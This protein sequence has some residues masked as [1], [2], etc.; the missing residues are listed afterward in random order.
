MQKTPVLS[1][2]LAEYLKNAEARHVWVIGDLLLDQYIE[3]GIERISPEAPV[4]VVNVSREFSRL[5]GAANVANGLA[6]LGINVTLAGVIGKDDAGEIFRDLCKS[7]EIRTDAVCTAEDRPT[8]RK[9]RVLCR[10][11]Q[12]IRLDW[13]RTHEISFQTEN[14]ILEA[15]SDAEPPDAVVISDYAKGVLTG[16]LIK[17]IISRASANHAS[18]AVDPK[19]KNFLKYRGAAVITPNLKEFREVADKR[20]SADDDDSMASAASVLCRNSGI[21]AVLVTMGE[22]GMGL[23]TSEGGLQRIEASAREVYDVTGAGD[24][25]MAALALCMANGADLHTAALISNAAA[26]IAVGKA[27]TAVVEPAELIEALSPSAH[28]KILDPRMLEQRLRLWRLQRKK[29]VFTNGCFDLLHAGHLH[30]LNQAASLGD[31][32]V[33]GINT[34]DSIRALNKGADRPLIPQQE[35]AAIVAALDCVN[36]VVLFDQETP[37]E[38]IRTIKPDV[39]AKGSDYTIDQVVGKEDVESYGGQVRLVNLLPDKSTTS[40]IRRIRERR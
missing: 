9:L 7:R 20:F 34:D 16:S 14:S 15:L 24:T 18:V 12:M 35:R 22:A 3:G 10:G 37:L 2:T 5:G 19:S 29:I 23:W 8:I 33:V 25:V 17:N 4:Q 6:A 11:Q 36:A 1:K 38:L 32:L 21:D 31:V 30:I 13:E 26:G 40:L 28:D 39:L 27:G